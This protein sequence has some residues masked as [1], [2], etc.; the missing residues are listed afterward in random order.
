VQHSKET[1]FIIDGRYSFEIGGKN[2]SNKQIGDLPN[3][4]VVKADLEYS[5]G[6]ALPLWLFGFLY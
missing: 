4:W 5:T 3:A 2:K 6:N 1:D